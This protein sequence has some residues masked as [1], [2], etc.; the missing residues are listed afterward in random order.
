MR[1]A[2]NSSRG[3]DA[4]PADS[5]HSDATISQSRTRTIPNPMS[6][7]ASPRSVWWQRA[8][9]LIFIPCFLVLASFWIYMPF[10]APDGPLHHFYGSRSGAEHH[11]PIVMAAS[12][13]IALHSLTLF[14]PRRLLFGRFSRRGTI[15]AAILFILLAAA[16]CVFA[17]L[18]YAAAFL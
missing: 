2:T 18:N 10:D 17:L 16:T 6:D 7:M 15:A 5:R 4:W 3:Q 14:L 9:W 1:A 12:I 8:D 11:S 13:V